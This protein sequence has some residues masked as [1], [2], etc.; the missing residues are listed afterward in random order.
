MKGVT[1]TTMRALEQHGLITIKDATAWTTARGR[2]YLN[3]SM[4]ARP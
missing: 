2:R 4:E 1:N 3:A